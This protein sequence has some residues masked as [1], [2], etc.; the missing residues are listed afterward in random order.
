MANRS[1]EQKKLKMKRRNRHAVFSGGQTRFAER[2]GPAP[3]KE[4]IYGKTTTLQR[5]KKVLV[6][7][8][9]L[10]K[11]VMNTG[12][13]PNHEA[14]QDYYR[15]I[16]SYDEALPATIGAMPIDQL[17][18]GRR[19]ESGLRL[20]DFDLAQRYSEFIKGTPKECH[21]RLV[22]NHTGVL[23]LYFT[24]NQWFFVDVDYQKKSLRRSK[25]YPSK[26][27]AISMMTAH[28]ITW[29]ETLSK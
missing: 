4:D 23:D 12:R 20:K 7:P 26:A 18:T 8:V 9:S 17:V 28:H 1:I 25:I 21:I 11:Q 15:R 13:G 22:D 14:M 16:H 10:S 19:T 24:L 3:F 6:G 5:D 29:V 27:Y 2:D